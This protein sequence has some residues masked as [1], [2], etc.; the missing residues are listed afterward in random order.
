MA[1]EY[2]AMKSTFEIE[3]MLEQYWKKENHLQL[4]QSFAR[5]LELKFIDI[6]V[7]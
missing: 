1:I 5:D 2:Q 6:E 4:F 3:S 7:T